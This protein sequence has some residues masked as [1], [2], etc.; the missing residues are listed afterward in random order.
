MNVTG[1]SNCY[2]FNSRLLLEPG[3]VL[4]SRD[5]MPHLVLF[6]LLFLL[7]ASLVATHV[8]LAGRG[9]VRVFRMVSLHSLDLLVLRGGQVV[10]LHI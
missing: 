1:V 6:L 7:S 5:L 10:N 3:L 9:G 8:H 4:G 2:I